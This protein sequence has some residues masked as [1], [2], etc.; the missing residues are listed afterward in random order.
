MLRLKFVALVAALSLIALGAGANAADLQLSYFPSHLLGS[1]NDPQSVSGCIREFSTEIQKQPNSMRAHIG[2]ATLLM[3]SGRPADAVSDLRFLLEK[4]EH[5]LTARYLLALCLLEARQASA[6]KIEVD[7]FLLHVADAPEALILKARILRRLGKEEEASTFERRA[8]QLGF[9]RDSL[10]FI[11]KTNYWGGGLRNQQFGQLLAKEPSCPLL[12][13]LRA[14]AEL[15]EYEYDKALADLRQCSSHNRGDQGLAGMVFLYTADAH[16][17]CGKSSQAIEA[18]THAIELFEKQFRKA[19]W[20]PFCLQE[21]PDTVRRRAY[22]LR[23]IAY[24]GLQKYDQ[25]IADMK[26]IIDE[27]SSAR[28]LER[29]VELCNQAG[30]YQ[31]AL[32]YCK[33]SVKSNPNLQIGKMKAYVGLQDHKKAILELNELLR[34]NSSD[35]TFLFLR[36]REYLR[37]GQYKQA[38]NDL[39]V[40]IASG[41]AA[42]SSECLSLR[43]E[44]YRKLGQDKLALADE[45][46]AKQIEKNRPKKL[47]SGTFK[48]APEIDTSL[49]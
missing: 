16:L 40:V 8:K 45:M 36:G 23:A 1:K 44:A 28:L 11:L 18:S 6:A 34:I 17:A 32:Q 38:I 20:L 46:R 41:E 31:L 24:S 2:R 29:M 25:A 30:R 7:K 43:A 19:D 15:G 14:K 12:Y 22:E 48:S 4:N 26:H 13:F 47:K 42:D 33:Q 5:D 49:Y 9:T 10:D 39:S 37:A 3:F 27:H 21:A 35:E